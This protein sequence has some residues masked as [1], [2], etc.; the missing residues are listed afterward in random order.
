MKTTL[1]PG[2]RIEWAHKQNGNSVI[3]NETLWSSTMNHY[4]PIGS[5]LV[6]TLVSIDDGQITWVNEE[7]C[8]HARVDDTSVTPSQ[9]IRG[10][11]V[12]RTC[13]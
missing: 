5:S 7:G 1:K 4:V 3:K 13:R 12:P 6:H 11:V 9:T 2:D 8:F 10:H